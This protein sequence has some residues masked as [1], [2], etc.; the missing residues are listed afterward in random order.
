MMDAHPPGASGEQQGQDAPASSSATQEAGKASS[1]LQQEGELAG[2]QASTT[3]AKEAFAAAVQA[4]FARIMAAGN[5]T[6]NE[7]ALQAIAAARQT[8]SQA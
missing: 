3:A 7:A 2:S 4:E 5:L 8:L 1:L 6:A